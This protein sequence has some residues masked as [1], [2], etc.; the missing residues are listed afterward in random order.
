MKRHICGLLR[1]ICV[2]MFHGLTWA[3]LFVEVAVQLR[4]SWWQFVRAHQLYP[5]GSLWKE[6]KSCSSYSL[7]RRK[8]AFTSNSEAYFIFWTTDLQG[9][10][11]DRYRQ[12]ASCDVS[13]MGWIL[14]CPCHAQTQSLYSSVSY[15]LCTNASHGLLPSVSAHLPSSTPGSNL[16]SYPGLFA[17][18]LAIFFPL[19]I[20]TRTHA[21]TRWVVD[22]AY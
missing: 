7:F 5:S 22:L 11:R 16:S 2:S 6:T 1:A 4:Q 19:E 15:P 9:K 13:L 21:L 17:V 18:F 14:P 3:Y 20:L 8:L 12:W 10:G